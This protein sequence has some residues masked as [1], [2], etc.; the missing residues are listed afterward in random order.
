MTEIHTFV[1]P[2]IPLHLRR[3]FISSGVHFHPPLAQADLLHYIDVVP[4]ASTFLIIDGYYKDV[5]SIWHKEILFALEN[6]HRVVGAASIGAIRA[7]ECCSYGMQ[8]LGRVFELFESGHLYDDSDVALLHDN[9]DYASLTI[10]V[11]DI[12]VTL[13]SLG[14]PVKTLHSLCNQARRVHYEDRTRSRLLACIHPESVDTSGIAAEEIASCLEHRLVNQKQR[15]A[16]DAIEQLLRD[17]L[18]PTS[19]SPLEPLNHTVFFDGLSSLD[20]PVAGKVGDLLATRSSFLSATLLSQPEQMAQL[21][22]EAMIIRVASLFFDS[23]EVDFDQDLYSKFKEDYLSRLDADGGA[24]QAVTFACLNADDI[25]EYLVSR[26]KATILL[27]SLHKFHPYS[28]SSRSIF[29]HAVLDPQHSSHAAEFCNLLESLKQFSVDPITEAADSP[30]PT[31]SEAVVQ[32]LMSAFLGSSDH[33]DTFSLG[34]FLDFETTSA[35]QKVIATHRHEL[36][37]FFV[38][39]PPSCP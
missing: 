17:D 21:E 36:L 19:T 10:P 15:D 3:D 22:T 6:G 11:C 7:A 4:A 18:P 16:V 32:R 14:L 2:S 38:R 30:V 20:R 35:F 23:I 24:R 5:P 26:F 29:S 13:D 25:E 28:M 8:G 31:W 27:G 37:R 34:S 1:G 39:Q 9:N 12:Y 33:R